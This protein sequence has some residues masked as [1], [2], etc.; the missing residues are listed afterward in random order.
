M[1]SKDKLIK[2]LENFE[3]EGIQD[4]S[5]GHTAGVYKKKPKNTEKISARNKKIWFVKQAYSP[6]EPLELEVIS[7]EVY[8]FWIG[9]TQP[10]T[11]LVT[12]KL[13]NRYVA[14]EGVPGFTTFKSIMEKGLEPTDY[15]TFARILVS[16]LVLA[17]TD[18]KSDN[19]GTNSNARSVK[20]DHDSSLWPFVK[21]IMS[22]ENDVNQINFSFEDLDD[23]LSP[24][25]FHPVIW[26]GGLKK[27]IKEKL[28][29]NELFKQEIYLQILRI[30]VYPPET[31]DMIQEVNAPADLELKE[32]I[33]SF[34]QERIN[35]LKTEALKSKEFRKF[36]LNL[37]MDTCEADFKEEL[38]EYF[39]DNKAYAGTDTSHSFNDSLFKIKAE[40]Q[41]AQ[42]I[43]FKDIFILKEKLKLDAQNP[44]H[45]KYWQEK[46][47]ADGGTKIQYGDLTYKVPMR[48][49]KM[50]QLNTGS[51]SSYKDFKDEI[52]RIRT[53][54][55]FALFSIFTGIKN[56]LVRDKTTQILYE[57]ENIE[58]VNLD[59][60]P[61]MP[62]SDVVIIEK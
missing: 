6:D 34:F 10:K 61:G 14:S 8:R 48:I 38:K 45:L 22:I 30:L 31:L 15:K 53:V 50:M 9:N 21:K 7:G 40:V 43:E 11:R 35:I 49:A 58:E 17:E 60:D 42:A 1:F 24:K 19:I 27:E 36:V 28:K 47:L 3:S 46:V 62:S 54:H 37:N 2:S 16:A 12:D 41:T 57:A 51:F 55:G 13:G 29:K 23:I 33:H 32:E 26:A 4:K 44:E 52:D 56:K 18:L 25:V 59:D 39:S 5:G 20:I